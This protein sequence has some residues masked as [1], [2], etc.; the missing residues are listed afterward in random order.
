MNWSM[1]LFF[2]ILLAISISTSYQL[3]TDPE[4]YLIKS[5]QKRIRFDESQAG[6][7]LHSE[8]SKYLGG[9]PNLEIWF[10]RIVFILQ[11]LIF[12]L[13]IAVAVVSQ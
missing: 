4:A 3:W 12:I 1:F 10:A 6:I 8:T 5:R 9:Q 13:G 2:L 7:L 11:Y